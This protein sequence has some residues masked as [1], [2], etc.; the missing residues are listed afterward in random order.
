[1]RRTRQVQRQNDHDDQRAEAEE[2]ETRVVAGQG[3]SEKF[4]NVVAEQLL[5]KEVDGFDLHALVA[6]SYRFPARRHFLDDEAK[7]DGGNDQINA[8]KP[9]GGNGDQHANEAGNDRG[10]R[11]V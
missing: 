7:G 4:V 10:G 1:G 8:R 3:E 9:K 11:E 2:I 6:V 5:A